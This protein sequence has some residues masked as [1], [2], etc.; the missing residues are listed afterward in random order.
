MKTAG[1]E[2]ELAGKY[3]YSVN[4]VCVGTIQYCP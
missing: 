4:G 3:K 2:L 1:I